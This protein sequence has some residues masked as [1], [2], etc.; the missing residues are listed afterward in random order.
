MEWPKLVALLLMGM[1]VQQSDAR[2][3]D[4]A[5]V[6][7]TWQIRGLAL[8][9]FDC[10]RAVCGRIVWVNDPNRRQSQC[11]KIIIWG[12]TPEGASKWKGG[13]ILDP[14]DGKTYR[15]AASMEHDGVLHARI[16]RGVPLLG[17]TEILRRVDPRTLTGHCQLP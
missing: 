13:S 12:L 9:I 8:E 17:R 7:G 4:G 2:S 5:S 1:T 10:E 6:N 11:G 3:A 15:L 14:D 16:Y